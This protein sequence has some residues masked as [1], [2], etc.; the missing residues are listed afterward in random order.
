MSRV[1]E[2][3]IPSLDGL[4]AISIVLVLFSH[5]CGTRGFLGYAA[6]HYTGGT[7]PLGVQV[8]FVISGFL[9]TGLLLKEYAKTG[10]ISVPAFYFRRAFRILP[11]FAVFISAIVAAQYAGWIRLNPGD[12]FH[13]LTY[14]IN[15]RMTTGW[16]VGHL[17]SLAVE[18]HFY[19]V[20]PFLMW[21]LGKRGG[22]LFAGA[23][24]CVSP[25]LRLLIALFAASPAPILA[26]QTHAVADAI[27]T[28]CVLAGARTWLHGRQWYLNFLYSRPVALAP[29]L[30]LAA[31][32]SPLGPVRALL[33]NTL[34]NLAVAVTIDRWTSRPHGGFGAL[35]NCR[36]AIFVGQISYSLYL[37]Q[38]PLLN[39]RIICWETSF[40][41]NLLLA[42]AAATASYYLVE[43]PFLR[44]RRR[45]ETRSAPRLIPPLTPTAPAEAPDEASPVRILTTH[46]KDFCPQW[47]RRTE[48]LP[49]WRQWFA[50][51]AR[52]PGQSPSLASEFLWGCKLFVASR[53]YDVVVTGW[54]RSALFFVAMQRL[55]RRNRKPHI[56]IYTLWN[57]PSPGIRRFLKYWQFRF[58]AGG[59]SRI[60]AYS[61]CQRALYA[62]TFRIPLHRIVSIPYYTTCWETEYTVNDG[63]YI[64]AGG[65]YTR[66]YC[67]LIEAIRGQPWRVIIAARF[68]H[69]FDG[70]SIPHNVE[71]RTVS[72]VEFFRL[73]AGAKVVVVPLQPGLLQSGGQQTYLNAMAM[74]KPVVVA[75]D[76]GANEYIRHNQT[77]MLV[78]PRDVSALRGALRALFE[79]PALARSIGENARQAA[80]AYAPSAFFERVLGLAEDLAPRSSR[81]PGR[82]ERRFRTRTAA[83]R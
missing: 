30:A 21:M 68:R 47:A 9:I 42:V 76:C 57:L 72:H 43:S 80:T 20:W 41:M 62:P 79:H 54:E 23:V 49:M 73:M 32:R 34:I 22:L 59:V 24:I 17:W 55:L 18:E 66:D 15:Y 28:G 40:P 65:D 78:P 35:L 16:E 81:L 4:R 52:H 26:Y 64:F 46:I 38:Q 25:F 70:L 2:S 45:I 39:H 5:L 50:N 56:L 63:E 61:D 10:R 1:T 29:L 77:G 33:I 71:I 6:L 67:S 83:S 74:G 53:R 82:I 11:A 8:F 12:L 31:N 7:G 44:L 36:A 13:A 58:I 69:Y 37:W 75:D 19:I 60:V 27:A 3:R 48:M 51:K 14:T